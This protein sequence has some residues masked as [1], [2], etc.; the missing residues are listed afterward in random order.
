V[1]I[2]ECR[3]SRAETLS[4]ASKSR[5]T[6]RRPVEAMLHRHPLGVKATKLPRRQFLH[7]AAGAAALP[8]V[9]RDADAQSYP[10]RPITL[11]APFPAG[12]T[13][14]LTA[15]IVADRMRSVLGQPIIVENVSG[16]NGTIG[17][18]RAAR[19]KPDGYTISL[20]HTG[21]HVLDAAFY[22][23]Q[24][25]VFNDFTPI[26]P[27]VRFP[28]VLFARR[29]L[30]ANDLHELIAWLKANSDS[31]S[32]G[33][34]SGGHRL[35]TALF[36]KETGTRFTLVPYRVA[37][38]ARQDLLAGQIDL[39]FDAPDQLSLAR[40]SNI[41]ILAT[42]G[43]MRIAPASEIPTFREFGLASL[44]FSNWYG[45]FAPKG[46][47]NDIVRKLNK[48]TVESLANASVKSRFLDAG[49]ELFPQSHQTPEA[50][51]A[52]MRVDADHWWPI[53]KELG[54]K[55]E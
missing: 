40:A 53:I 50:L 26:S 39:L 27:L 32:A 6:Q 42:T 48:A 45:L 11:I 16:A 18:A 14:D 23:L 13:V 28:Y 41:K 31:A 15:R 38:P 36:Q 5:R 9:S 8:A 3:K 44:S 10:V 29:T 46:T 30:P 34:S 2:R 1:S 49:L 55:A 4:I 51:A 21:T 35:I 43:E 47:A 19:A 7:L 22:S 12:S 52:L 25:D 33:F 20:G 24:Y 17:V 37:N 54:I